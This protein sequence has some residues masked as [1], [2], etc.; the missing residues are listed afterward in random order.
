MLSFSKN[1]LYRCVLALLSCVAVTS[2]ADVLVI[3]GRDI[4]KFDFKSTLDPNIIK[5]SDSATGEATH[6]G[7]YRLDASELVNLA[8]LEITGGWF[9]MTAAN[10]DTLTGVYSGKGHLTE[11]P[12]VILYDVAGPI[13]GGTGRYAGATGALAFFGSADLAAGTFTDTVLAVV[14]GTK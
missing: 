3:K 8:T 9:T 13:T 4:G 1:T 2:A 7:R 11:T 5:T 12:S 14:S 10:G 6:F